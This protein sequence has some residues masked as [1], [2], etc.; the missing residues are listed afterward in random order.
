M[1][2][3]SDEMFSMLIAGG[4]GALVAGAVTF[5]G[6]GLYQTLLESFV[7]EVKEESAGGMRGM[8]SVAIRKLGAWNRKIMWPGYEARMRKQLIRAGEPKAYKPEDIMALQEVGFVLGVIGGLIV[9]NGLNQSLLWSLAVG[10]IGGVYPLIWV[11]DQVTKRHLLISRALPYNLDLLTLSVEAGLDF[12]AALAKVVEKGKPGP[13]RD[14]MQLVLKQ[15]KLG[16]TREEALK[17]MVARVDLP[18]LTMFVTALIQADRMGTS[19]GKILRIQSTQMRIERTQRA[20]K[21]ANEAP[22][23]MLFPLIA[24]IF[25]TVFMILFSPIVFAFM[26][27]HAASGG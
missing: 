23:K 13:L 22:V 26:F 6:I 11:R 10:L 9:A 12:T 14:E 1:Q 5:L 18:A 7:S 27:G 8:G 16:K 19:L 25:P 17:A 2:A 24:C 15:L 3:M 20:E 21:L 4:T